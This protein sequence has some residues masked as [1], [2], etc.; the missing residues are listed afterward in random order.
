MDAEE[1]SQCLLCLDELPDRTHGVVY[2]EGCTVPIC[3]KCTP[4]T[5]MYGKCLYCSEII[6]K[7]VDRD[8]QSVEIRCPRCQMRTAKLFVVLLFAKALIHA[9]LF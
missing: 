7:V 4:D 2:F 8:G 9:L 6:D 5:Y 1:G 3:L